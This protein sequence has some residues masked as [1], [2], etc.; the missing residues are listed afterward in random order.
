MKPAY[1]ASVR[2]YSQVLWL[3]GDDYQI[4]EV[5]SMN[6]FFV[7]VNENGKKEIVTPPLDRGDILPGVTRRSILELARTWDEYE[8]SE[9]NITMDEVR[10]AAKE[11]RLLEAFGA[12]TAAVVTPISCI[13]FKGEEIE[14]PATGD[15][16]MKVWDQ[17]TG[18]QYG[19]IDHEWS[20]KV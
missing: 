7:W 2:G 16:T 13:E 15:I 12:G 18:I 9:K 20:V 6:V 14:I 11:G 1:E 19:T 5:G 17:L 3:F 10:E 4:T 8:V